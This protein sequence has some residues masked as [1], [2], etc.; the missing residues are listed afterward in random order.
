MAQNAELERIAEQRIR[1]ANETLAA[2]DLISRERSAGNIA[3]LHEL[4]A[5][6]MRELGDEAAAARALER[7]ERTR[8]RL[9]RRGRSR[10]SHPSDPLV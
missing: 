5:R 7:A 6:H 8:V 2:L 3:A 1:H 4:H 9:Q 10:S